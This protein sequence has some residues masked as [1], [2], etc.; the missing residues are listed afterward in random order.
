LLLTVKVKRAWGQQ[1]A[2]IPR[3][4]ILDD[5][6]MWQPFGKHCASSDTSKGTGHGFE[7]TLHRAWPQ[8]KTRTSWQAIVKAWSAALRAPGGASTSQARGKR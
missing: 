4:G 5:V 3:I 7:T 8:S 2:K 6:P 1:P